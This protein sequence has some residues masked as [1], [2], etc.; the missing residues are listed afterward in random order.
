[1]DLQQRRKI[2]K[3]LI[4]LTLSLWVFVVVLILVV[5]SDSSDDEL[6]ETDP[7]E[8]PSAEPAEAEPQHELSNLSRSSLELFRE[9][10]RVRNFNSFHSGG[11]HFLE[12]S[13]K[14]DAMP[15]LDDDD[16]SA[17]RSEIGYAP[18]DLA[19]LGRIYRDNGGCTSD[20]HSQAME[21]RLL[22]EAKRIGVYGNDC[23]GKKKAPVNSTATSKSASSS[24]DV[25]SDA[26]C[27]VIL[28][29]KQKDL[30]A[31]RTFCEGFDPGLFVGVSADGPLLYLWVNESMARSMLSDQLRSK[32]I[33]LSLMKSWKNLSD[34]P[35]VVVKVYWDDILVMTGDT[36]VMRGDVV[37]FN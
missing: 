23:I 35:S 1:M 31:A 6:A 37:T 29:D 13:E 24:N 10:Y 12:W 22:K 28:A 11:T 16:Q 19:W 3:R 20:S 14:I 30:T 18:V 34:W 36:T 25:H 4:P 21:A 26:N 33:M 15:E 5:R 7:A 17:V 27:T 32:S 8:S 9:L 2:N